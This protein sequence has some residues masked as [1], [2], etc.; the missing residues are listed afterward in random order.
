MKLITVESFKAATPTTAD[1]VPD[2]WDEI[3]DSAAIVAITCTYIQ[4]LLDVITGLG[5]FTIT[6]SIRHNNI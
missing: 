6:V 4:I 2:L 5:G 3:W 1:Q